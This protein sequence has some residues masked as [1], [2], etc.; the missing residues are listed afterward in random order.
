VFRG[1]SILFYRS[2]FYTAVTRAKK[3]LILVGSEKKIAEMV[4]NH[5]SSNRYSGLKYFLRKLN[6]EY[7]TNLD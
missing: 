6:A 4:K 5:R 7:D 1:P 2:L 3:I